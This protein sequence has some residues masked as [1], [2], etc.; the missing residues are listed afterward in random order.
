MYVVTPKEMR[1]IDN[2]AIAEFGIP[3]VVL[4]ENA[5]I[6]TLEVIEREYP[7]LLKEG[8]ILV[9]V[10]S[11][12]NGGDG[13]AIARHLMLKGVAVEALLFFSEGRFVGDAKINLDIYK[14]LG[15]QINLIV[16]E[17]HKRHKEHEVQG[18]MLDEIIG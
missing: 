11:G 17:D 8:K 5:A 16:Q 13:L 6:R 10:G 4:M 15:G 18:S 2:R 14:R 1:E 3:G 9:L 7:N 12:N